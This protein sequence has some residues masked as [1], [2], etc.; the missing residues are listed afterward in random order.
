LEGDG[1]AG[2]AGTG[3]VCFLLILFVTVV[4]HFPL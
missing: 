2:T 1:H 4:R 3:F